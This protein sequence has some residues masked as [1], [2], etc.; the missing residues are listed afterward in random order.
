MNLSLAPNFQLIE[1][2]FVSKGG[3]R[4]IS[5]G[6]GPDFIVTPPDST[7][8]DQIKTV[9]SYADMLGFEWDALPTTKI[10]GYYGQAHYG[11]AYANAGSTFYGY[12]F[13]GSANSNN[14][15]IEE[16]TVGLTQIFW[17]NPSYGDLKFLLQLS[18]LDRD[19]WFVATGAPEKAHL[20]MIYADLRYDLP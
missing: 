19:P 5:T 8:T 9:Y 17:K 16:Y 3:G 15:L 11:K 10:Y 4:Y 6:L 7:G 12:G 13:A 1:N 2:A 18:Y 20:G 14:K